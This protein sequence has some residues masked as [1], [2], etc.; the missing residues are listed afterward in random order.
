MK[1]QKEQR[2]AIE[3]EIQQIKDLEKEEKRKEELAMKEKARLRAEE[4][5]VRQRPKPKA[6]LPKEE[7]DFAVGHLIRKLYGQL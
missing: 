4:L 7:D 3:K 1:L 6:P 2:A 5:K